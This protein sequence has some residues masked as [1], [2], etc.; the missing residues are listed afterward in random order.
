MSVAGAAAG[1][2]TVLAGVGAGALTA[3]QRATNWGQRRFVATLQLYFVTVSMLIVGAGFAVSPMARPVF[4]PPSWAVIG[5]ALVLGI[6][7]G[8]VVAR[9]LAPS[10]AKRITFLIALIGA[11]IALADGMAS[12]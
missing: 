10:A 7:V 1:A 9:R 3:L 4:S 8:D 11:G 12:L 5:I 2:M 6:R